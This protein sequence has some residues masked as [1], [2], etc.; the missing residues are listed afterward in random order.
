[1]SDR[2]DRLPAIRFSTSKHI[3]QEDVD[4]ANEVFTRVL[5]H[6]PEPVL[7]AHVTLS[8]LPDP[9]AQSPAMASIR[10]DLNG[11]PVNAHAAAPVMGHA[12]ALA[13]DRLRIRLER[14]SRNWEARRGRQR[15]EAV[16]S[17]GA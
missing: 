3:P 6:A 4:R 17:Q 5:V 1:L 12:I 14:M 8:L 10:V 16:P 7:S 9:A 15:T 2:T 11:R 13:G